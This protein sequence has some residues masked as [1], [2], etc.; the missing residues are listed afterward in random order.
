MISCSLR[1]YECLQVLRR[2]TALQE[3]SISTFPTPLN[4]L[5]R[6]RAL[7]TCPIVLPSLHTL[8]L[9]LRDPM[10]HSV[11]FV[12]ALCIPRLRS[13]RAISSTSLPR[14][15]LPLFQTLLSEAMRHLDLS[16]WTPTDLPGA[17]A[18]APNLETLK[19]WNGS[20]EVL[21]MLTAVPCLVDLSLRRADPC[22]LFN[23]LEARVAAM[24]SD[25]SI[26]VI[27]N[28][29]VI[30]SSAGNMDTARLAALKV[31]GVQIV[32]RD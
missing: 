21:Q 26:S 19:L 18:L 30:N 24:R 3:C 28:V 11:P 20:P 9:D 14:A 22:D 31:A 5:Q 10:N 7:F 25:N 8:C 4:D 17:L 16:S 13:L 29:S 27:N 32:F 1:E 15:L 12:H 2:C 6:V 23:M